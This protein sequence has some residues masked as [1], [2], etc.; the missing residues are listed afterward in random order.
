MMTPLK[1]NHEYSPEEIA[2][3]EANSKANKKQYLLDHP[4][5]R[6]ETT[7][8][9]RDRYPEAIEKRRNNPEHAREVEQARRDRAVRDKEFYCAVCNW[10][11]AKQTKLDKHLKG[12]K[13][14][15]AVKAAKTK[16]QGSQS[17]ASAG[18]F[19]MK[20]KADVAGLDIVQT[21]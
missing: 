21:G 11:F 3:H 18:F 7:K 13:H 15:A 6:R 4:E 14:K 20:R 2:Q 19:T 5:Q 9:Y 1:G 10:P 8:R 17:F 12:P 16:A